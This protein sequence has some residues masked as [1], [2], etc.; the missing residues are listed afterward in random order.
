MALRNAF[1]EVADGFLAFLIDDFL[2]VL[3]LV[4]D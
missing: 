1:L 4:G 3:M 2:D